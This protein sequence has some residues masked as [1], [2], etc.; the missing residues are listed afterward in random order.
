MICH[1]QDLLVEC[2]Q[3]VHPTM[4]N[5]NNKK[6]C[7]GPAGFTAVC[8]T[9]YIAHLLYKITENRKITDN[10]TQNRQLIFLKPSKPATRQHSFLKT[11]KS[12][13][14]RQ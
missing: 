12:A 13:V 11:T 2:C 9:L 8:G 4:S 6:R 5:K 7:D 1:Y 14:N 3:N 10:S